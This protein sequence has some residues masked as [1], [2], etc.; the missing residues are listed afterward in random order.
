MLKVIA[1]CLKVIVRCLNVITRY[2][3]SNVKAYRYF[4]NDNESYR[5]I[6]CNLSSDRILHLSMLMKYRVMIYLHRLLYSF[7]SLLA[8]ITNFETNG[9]PYIAK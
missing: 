7:L 6:E 8:F 9:L 5:A 4:E 2:L 1:R 3:S